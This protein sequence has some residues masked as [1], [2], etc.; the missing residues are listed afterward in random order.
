MCC[1]IVLSDSAASLIGYV[2]STATAKKQQQK[3]KTK[4]LQAQKQVFKR[5]QPHCLQVL[6]FV[7]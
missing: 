1:A 4:K 6:S 3:N 2:A 7:T 5:G